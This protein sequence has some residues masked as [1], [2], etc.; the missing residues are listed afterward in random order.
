[1]QRGGVLVNDSP[2]SFP[3]QASS[4]PF[5]SPHSGSEPWGPVPSCQVWVCLPGCRSSSHSPLST[6]SQCP[7]D[8]GRCSGSQGFSI[9]NH[10]VSNLIKLKGLL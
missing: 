6:P 1:M 3:L 8:P 10:S 9:N 4:S 7:A 5:P 2:E